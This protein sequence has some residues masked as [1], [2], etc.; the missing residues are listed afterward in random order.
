M[1]QYVKALDTD[2]AC[3]QY[4]YSTFPQLSFE[5]IKGG[6]FD[7]PQIRTLMKDVNFIQSMNET[8]AA[9][10][11]SFVDVVKNVLGNHK[12][13]NYEELVLS[14]FHDLGIHMS[15]KVHYLHTHLDCFSHNLGDYSE[16]QGERFHQDIKVMEE[17]YQVRWDDNMMADYCWN[18]L[19][20]CPHIEHSRNSRKRSF[21]AF[22]MNI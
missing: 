20:D 13:D 5:K 18:L 8:E 11:L 6:I 2:G 10:W 15:I 1:K 21:Y 16:E 22:L 7:G 19:R 3:F 12:A 9:A 4:I 17:R 14:K